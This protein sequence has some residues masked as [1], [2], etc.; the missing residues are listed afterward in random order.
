MRS[1]ALKYYVCTTHSHV[2]QLFSHLYLLNVFCKF[3]RF[4]FSATACL[5]A[6]FSSGRYVSSIPYGKSFDLP[7]RF[8]VYID[9]S[10][11]LTQQSRIVDERDAT[12]S[13][14]TRAIA[15]ANKSRL[16]TILATWRRTYIELANPIVSPVSISLL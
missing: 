15:S 13:S 2:F 12:S 3:A 16:V 10:H 11:H 14:S 5:A 6:T 8:S 1:T 7:T 9:Q 4:Y